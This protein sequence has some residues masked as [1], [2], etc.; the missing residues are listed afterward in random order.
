MREGIERKRRL[1]KQLGR[2]AKL[3]S[4]TPGHATWLEWKILE[5]GRRYKSTLTV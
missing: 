2:G 4:S 5:Y 1:L 3:K